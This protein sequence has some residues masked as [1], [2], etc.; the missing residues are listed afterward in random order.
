MKVFAL[1]LVW[2]LVITS[3]PAWAKPLKPDAVNAATLKTDEGN[4]G[5]EVLV[6]AQ[7]ILDR[8][9]YSPGVID[10]LY[11]D[12]T[13]IA[14]RT[15]Q[16]DH[17]MEATGK[18]DEPSFAKLTEV[19]AEPVLTRYTITA[20][21]VK[22]PFAKKI[23]KDIAAMAKLKRMAFTGPREALSERFHMDEALLTA[24]NPGAD[25]RKHGA[26][27]TVAAVEGKVEE[28]RASAEEPKAKRIVIDKGDRTLRV[29]GEN[30]DL[31]A[32][33]PATIGSDENPAPSG[34]AEGDRRP[35]QPLLELRSQAEA[36]RPQEPARQKTED[37]ARPQQPGRTGLD[38]PQQ[39]AFRHPR[40][41]R[42]GKDR[43]DAVERLRAADELGRA[44]IGG[45]GEEG[46]AGAVRGVSLAQSSALL[47]STWKRCSTW[48][49]IGARTKPVA[50]TMMRPEKMA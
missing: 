21:D 40:L 10:G 22:G 8:T 18:L 48:W 46:H 42:A 36:A 9:R 47:V 3:P 33:Y 16:A 6:R 1:W 12:S 7:V 43:Q 32:V 45:P 5:R 19:D 35:S 17:G 24:L 44:G 41:P 13:E 37:P 28:G 23:P 38:R 20:E 39:G 15:F 30:D 11:G 49:K 34:R 50:I 27:I 29:L 26:E 31:I 4:K 2:F 14:L 25:F